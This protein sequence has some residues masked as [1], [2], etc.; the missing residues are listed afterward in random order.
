[1]LSSEESIGLE[2]PLPEKAR[3]RKW[4]MVVVRLVMAVLL[5]C[6]FGWILHKSVSAANARTEPAGL[7]RGILHGALMPGAW[8]Y[9]IVGKDVVIYAENNNGRLYKLG[10]T[11]GVNGCGALFFGGFYWRL[12]RWRKRYV[13][14]G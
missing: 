7:G 14:R 5:T 1:M 8:P 10:Y 3:A 11:M 6:G 9:L 12:N 4:P 2:V 13:A